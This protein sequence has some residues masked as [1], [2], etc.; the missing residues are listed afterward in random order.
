MTLDGIDVSHD[1]ILEEI[2]WKRYLSTEQWD[3]YETGA[4][5]AEDNPRVSLSV[6]YRFF[7]AEEP[8][9][10][11]SDF[12]DAGTTVVA[13]PTVGDPPGRQI[14][15]IPDADPAV[16]PDPGATR[17]L[18]NTTYYLK[19]HPYLV[20]T[21]WA[22]GAAEPVKTSIGYTMDTAVKT[23][24]TPKLD[25][26]SLDNITRD[27]RAPTEFSIA[28]DAD[29]ALLLTDAS[30]VM[31]WMH[32]EPDVG[33]ELMVTSAMPGADDDPAMYADDPHL[34]DLLAEYRTRTPNLVSGQVLWIPLDDGTALPGLETGHGLRLDGETLAVTFPMDGF[35]QPNTQYYFSLRAIRDRGS[36]DADGFPSPPP[37]RWITVPVTTPMVKAPQGLE[38]VRDIEIGFTV[39]S[40]LSRGDPANYEIYVKRTAEPDSAYTLLSRARYTLVRD[41]NTYYWRVSGLA[42]DTWYDFRL[43][44][45][46]PDPKWYDAATGTWQETVGAPVPRK[47]RDALHELEVRWIGEPAYVYHLEARSE[48]EVDYVP[49]RYAASGVTDIGYETADGSREQYYLER[50]ATQVASGSVEKMVYAR[51]LRKRTAQADGSMLSV[52]LQTNRTYSVR[53]WARNPAVA[54]TEGAATLKADSVRVGPVSSRTD[55]SQTDYDLEKD[56]E[57]IIALYEDEAEQLTRKPY[58]LVDKG[59]NNAV[60]VLLKGDR[61]QAMLE[62]APEA[63]QIIS[64]VEELADASLYEITIPEQ[65]VETLRR[66]DGRLM[67]RVAGAEYLLSR[68]SFNLPEMKARVASTQVRETMLRV[69]IERQDTLAAPLPAVYTRISKAYTFSAEVLG[70]RYDKGYLDDVIHDI[71]NEPLTQGPFKYGLL[72][73]ER[74]AL[75]TNAA[76]YTYRVHTDLADTVGSLVDRVEGQMSRYL[77]DLLDGGSGLPALAVQRAAVTAYPGAVLVSHAYTY[78]N[79]RTVPLMLPAGGGAWKE[80][81][82]TRAFTDSMA[83]FRIDGP[84]TTVIGSSRGVQGGSAVTWPG[85]SAIAGKY[86]LSHAFGLKP[87]YPTNTV[88]GQEAVLLFELLGEQ[89]REG[90]GLSMAQKLQALGLQE[91]IATRTLLLPL[92]NQRAVSWSVHLY[93]RGMGQDIAQMQPVATPVIANLPAILPTLQKPVV[94]GFD[95]GLAKLPADRRFDATGTASLGGLMEMAHKVLTLLGR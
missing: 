30:V 68:S 2:D 35:L 17:I 41:G 83:A 31:Q 25:L 24:T 67:F 45:I 34:L 66:V 84:A 93:A 23:I 85:L 65:V 60:R 10:D 64:L 77:K 50:T 95:L 27:P 6:E 88:T 16:D 11:P 94:M 56:K 22:D 26:V 13:Y 80:P 89:T 44:H 8:P 29:G 62:S 47:T 19:A 73:R 91:V 86:D 57:N 82:G 79:G 3:L 43:R 32:R 39:T 58:W 20:V 87:V 33:Y 76:A 70:G 7:I 75:E 18:P 49:L 52:P 5:T 63:T 81:A 72:D 54:T 21:E 4:V 90:Q 12:E 59:A 51:I 36:V 46:P 69:R 74:A 48:S 28:T 15:I 14:R 37:S 55:F 1:H 38:I 9:A 42:S 61:V 92:D 71:L 78:D 53:L 40:T